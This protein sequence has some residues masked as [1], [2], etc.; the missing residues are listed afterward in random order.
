M[1][2]ADT[3]VLASREEPA[4]ILDYATLTGACVSAITKKYSGVFTNRPALHPAL[5]RV[6]QD[7]GERVWPFP[8]GAEFMDALKSDTLP[9]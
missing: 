2:L 9:I 8:I 6:G 3:L 7:S 5:R 1:A 4:L